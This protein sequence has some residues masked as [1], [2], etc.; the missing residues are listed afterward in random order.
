MPLGREG[1]HSGYT[2]HSRYQRLPYS[3]WH[4]VLWLGECTD[5][6]SAARVNNQRQMFQTVCKKGSTER[7]SLSYNWDPTVGSW[8]RNHWSV[9]LLVPLLA[10]TSLELWSPLFGAFSLASVLSVC[11][12]EILSTRTPWSCPICQEF[13]VWF[14]SRRSKFSGLGRLGSVLSVI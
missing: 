1:S 14:C 5:W 2:L 11:L 8:E 4:S 13:D 7:I 9:V 12:L 10:V 3:L 6:A